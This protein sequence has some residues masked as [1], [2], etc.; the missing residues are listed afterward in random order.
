MNKYELGTERLTVFPLTPPQLRLLLDDVKAFEQEL[1]CTYDGEPLTGFIYNIM[2]GQYKVIVD[3]IDNY[4]WHTFWMI[5]HNKSNVV[6]GSMCFKGLPD[7]NSDVEIG[8]GINTPYQNNN[9]ITEAVK[10]IRNWAIQQPIVK[11]FIAETEKDNIASQRVLQ[12]C[13][14]KIYKETDTCFWWR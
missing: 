4:L 5:L 14:M 8:Y 9:Y 13:S 11:G 10:A 6:I 1:A 12:K 2:D 3:D 7:A